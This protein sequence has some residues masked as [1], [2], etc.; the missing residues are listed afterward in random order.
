MK[1]LLCKNLWDFNS[2][3]E[4]NNTSN[5]EIMKNHCIGIISKNG[6]PYQIFMITKTLALAEPSSFLSPVTYTHSYVGLNRHEKE[7]TYMQNVWVLNDNWQM[8][9]LLAK[10][11]LKL[12]KHTSK[13]TIELISTSKWR[14]CIA[15]ILGNTIYK[16]TWY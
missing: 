6:K 9:L 14:N 11:K 5:D 15:A 7:A 13:N 10:M 4:K 12:L 1:E 8:Q 2:K 3:V 16:N